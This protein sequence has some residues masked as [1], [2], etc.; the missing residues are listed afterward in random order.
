MKDNTLYLSKI[1]TWYE[2]D[3]EK[4]WKGTSTVKEFIVL[5]REAMSLNQSQVDAITSGEVEVDYLDYDWS[6]NDVKP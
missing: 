4:N 3:F 6:L 1:F 5:Y 2:G